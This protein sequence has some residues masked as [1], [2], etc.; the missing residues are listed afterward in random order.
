MR[1]LPS[2]KMLGRFFW[3]IGIIASLT[4]GI[5][6]SLVFILQMEETKEYSVVFNLW[7]GVYLA[8][9]FVT[10]SLLF[11]M[12][13]IFVMRIIVAV[14]DEI[15]DPEQEPEPKPPKNRKPKPGDPDWQIDL[16]DLSDFD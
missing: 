7:H 1:N 6:L 16:G 2:Q 8:S 15:H 11:I 3:A 4:A 12:G 13:V 5:W 10:I 14:L 9:K